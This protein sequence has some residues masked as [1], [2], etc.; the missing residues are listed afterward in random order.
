[1][2]RSTKR[3]LGWPQRLPRS[4][5]LATAGHRR[6]HAKHVRYPDHASPGGSEDGEW[7]ID[8]GNKAQQ[9]ANYPPF[10]IL[11]CRCLGAAQPPEPR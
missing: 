3:R 10:S 4:R 6:Q 2:L 11:Y 7:K 8:D 1:M 5:Q 9:V